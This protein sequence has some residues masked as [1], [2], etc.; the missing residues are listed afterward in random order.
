L[1]KINLKPSS[2]YFNFSGSFPK[3]LSSASL[4]K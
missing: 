4:A 1:W 3:N 2:A